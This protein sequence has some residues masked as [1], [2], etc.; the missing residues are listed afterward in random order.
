LAPAA[1]SVHSPEILAGHYFKA[2]ITDLEKRMR[3]AAANLEFEEAARFRD[4][5]KRLQAGELAIAGDPLASQRD[6][7]AEAGPMQA[8]AAAQADRRIGA[9]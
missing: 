8:N 3:G 5:L 7:E 4:E 2:T 1:G 6:V 9:A